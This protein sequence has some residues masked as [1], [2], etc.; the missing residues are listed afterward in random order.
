MTTFYTGVSL[1]P[2]VWVVLLVSA[3]MLCFCQINM[4]LFKCCQPLVTNYTP[5]NVQGNP[6]QLR[7]Q[8]N[9]QKE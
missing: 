2:W 1:L 4:L 5:F 8:Q 7:E 6:G 9:L 3:H